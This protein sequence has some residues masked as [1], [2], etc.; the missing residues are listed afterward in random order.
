MEVLIRLPLRLHALIYLSIYLQRLQAYAAMLSCPVG[1]IRTHQPD[2]LG[3]IHRQHVCIIP[4]LITI[5][6]LWQK[7]CMHVTTTSTTTTVT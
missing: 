5:A 2:P 1:S 7:P 4:M 6:P 3:V